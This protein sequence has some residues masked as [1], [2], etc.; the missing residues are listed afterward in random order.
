MK[1]SPTSPRTDDTANRGI[2]AALAVVVLAGL[3]FLLDRWLGTTP[4][5]SVA[6][7]VVGA[8]GVF[9]TL[10]YR[11]VDSMTRLEAERLQARNGAPTA[12]EEI[13]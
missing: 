8:V 10:K 9:A 12:T 7:A 3:G 13:R 11:Y 4:L 1:T 6:F 5:F 2:E